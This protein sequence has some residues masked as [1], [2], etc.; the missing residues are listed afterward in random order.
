[1]IQLIGIQ[2]LYGTL[3]RAM[4]SYDADNFDLIIDNEGIGCAIVQCECPA[5]RS[6]SSC[7]MVSNPLTAVAETQL[8]Q[9]KVKVSSQDSC[10][11]YKIEDAATKSVG[12]LFACI[13]QSVPCSRMRIFQSRSIIL[14]IHFLLYTKFVQIYYILQ[15][16]I[17]DINMIKPCGIV[18]Y[19]RQST[20][21]N[22]TIVC[23][24][25]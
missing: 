10:K 17:S 7:I 6:E 24:R 5:K 25:S 3:G 8:S 9:C 18:N 1:M 2:L 19:T 11:G 21:N 23:Q 22:C 12:G 14:A 4:D 20:S 16:D 13:G 15:V